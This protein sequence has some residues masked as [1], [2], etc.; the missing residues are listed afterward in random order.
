MSNQFAVD[1]PAG[2][3]HK[4]TR[5]SYLIFFRAITAQV[6]TFKSKHQEFAP[7]ILTTQSGTQA[8]RE[9]SRQCP[10]P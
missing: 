6:N 7:D 2:Y 8:S 4:H 9:E 1:V 10:Y 5:K 3:E